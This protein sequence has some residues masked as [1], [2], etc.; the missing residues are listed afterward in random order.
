MQHFIL[1]FKISS[2]FAA[3]CLPI[4]PHTSINIYFDCL[5]P[6]TSIRASLSNIFNSCGPKYP[7]LLSSSATCIRRYLLTVPKTNCLR[8]ASMS[9][10]SLCKVAIA[11]S[12]SPYWTSIIEPRKNK[13]HFIQLKSQIRRY[14]RRSTCHAWLL[15]KENYYIFTYNQLT[16]GG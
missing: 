7:N 14:I 8:L 11:R 12:V 10:P 13:S 4:I 2:E 15:N 3:N 16:I 1:N 6:T 9:S 5:G